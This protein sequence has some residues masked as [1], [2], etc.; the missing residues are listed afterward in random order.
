MKNI[1]KRLLSLAIALFMVIAMIPAGVLTAS[2]ATYEKA[3]SIAVGD[4][5]ILVCES[6]GMEMSS[7]GSAK[8]GEGKAYSGSPA[9]LVELTVEAGSASD[10]FAFKTPA[11]TY[12]YWSSSNTLQ[13]TS[14]V[15][16]NSSWNVTFTDGNA[17]IANVKDSTRV[18]LWNASSP[19]F[20]CYTSNQTAIQLY[21][22][23]ASSVECEH[24]YVSD[25]NA[26]AATCTET[27]LTASVSC[28]LCGD[29]QTKQEEIAALGHN[30]VDGICSRCGEEA[31]DVSVATSIAVG[32]TVY[33][34]YEDDSKTV[35][36]A[37]ISDTSTKYGL[38]AAYSDVPAGVMPL[39]VVAGNAEGTVAFQTAD[40][41]YLTWTSGNSLNVN[42]TLSDN[43][44]W[45]VSFDEDGY[46]VILNGADNTRKLQWNNNAGQERFAAY[47]STQKLVKLYKENAEEQ[48]NTHDLTYYAAVEA[49]CHQNGMA[50]YW[51]CAECD[52]VFADEAATIVTNR[53]NLTI[54]YTAEIAHVE[55]V[56]ANCHQNGNVEYWYC[57]ECEAVFTDAALTQLSNFK[58]VIIPA[59][60]GLTHVE[61]VEAG[62]H[63][64]GCQEY[65]YC[66][67]C[68]CVFADAAA[69]MLTN[70]K[71]LVIVAEHELAYVEA[72]EAGLHQP[73]VAE[74][75][76]C[77]DCDAFFAD[78]N[79]IQLTNYKNLINGEAEHPLTY[80]PA[81]E[82]GL[83]QNGVAE[84]WYCEI[85]D[86]IF[87][88]ANGIVLT[89]YKNL[90]NG[91]AE[92]P[93]TYVPAVEAGLHQN[94][95]AEYWYCETC[96]AIFADA[97]GIQLTNYKN[98]INGE[99]EHPL[100]YVAA[101]EAGLHTNGCAEYWY[102][103]TCDAVFADPNGIQLT[104][105]KNLV[106]L[107]EH[108]LAYVE[109]VEAG[110]HQNGVAEYWYC[111]D[112][113]AFFADADGI[114]LTN[115]K[116]LI[117][118]EAEHPLTYVA[119]VEAGV[120]TNGCAEYWYCETCDA[121]F[122]DPNG[123]QLTNRKN[124]V[125]V[126]EHELAYVEAVEAG[127]H[128]NGVAEYWY[129]D[130]C[131]AF[132][133]DAD[134]IYQ[135][136]Y[137]NLI[138]GEAEHPL[139]YVAAVEAGLHQNGVA[140]YWYCEICDAIFADP[141]GIQLTNYKNL[142]NGEAEHPLT[143]VAAVEA[144][145]HT[146]G[147][148][149]YWY[150]ETCDAVFAD[151]NGIQLTNRKNLV[152]LAEH[153]LAYVAAVEA[154]LH[155]NG[156]AEYWYC[157]DCDAFFADAD[158]IYQTNYKNL[159]NGEA[160][161]PLT[162][163]AAVE[164][165]LHQNGV[166]EYWYCEI[167][168]A[169]FADPNGIQLTNYKNLIN[170]EAEHPLTYVA[171]VEAT[172]HQPGMAEYWYC[173]VC[174]AFF[175]DPNGIQ[176]T[177]AKN[178]ITEPAAPLTYVAAVEAGLH[179][180]GCAEYWYCEECMAVFTDAQGT[181]LTNLKNLVIVAEHE[182]AYVEAVEA[183]LHQNGV[184]EYWYCDDCDAFFA[185][186]D[187]IVLT[188]YKNLI[189]GYAEHPLT[190]VAAVEAGLHQNGVAEYWYCEICDTI[191]A[192]ANGIQVTNYKNLINGYAEHPLTYVP[193][194]EAGLHQNGVAEYWYCEIC[195][196]IF[197][198]ANGIQLTNY[199]NLIN[200]EAEHPLTYVPAV[201][202]TCH[203]PGMAEYWYCAVCDAFFA[204]PNGIQLTNAK[205]L[206]TEPAAPL[207]YVPAVAPTTEQN[208][209]YEYWY[210]ETCDAV[211]ADAQG[212][213]LTNRLNLTIPMLTKVEIT[214][215]PE[216]VETI[217]NSEVTFTVVANGEGLTYK[218]Q[219]STNGGKSWYK[220]SFVGKD[221]ATLTVPATAA[222]DG[223][224]YRCVITDVNGNEVISEA[225]KLTVKA[226]IS[227]QP[228]DVTAAAGTIVT[229][230]ANVE[231]VEVASY[232]WQYSTNGGQCWFAS[233]TFEG[234][235][236]DTLYVP[237]TAARDGFLYRCVIT[238]ADGQT[239]I[240]EAAELNVQ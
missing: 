138:N 230:S 59:T 79:G 187:G 55:A 218:W 94:G 41:K 100:T 73:G 137:K 69:T 96:D 176:L 119:A 57:T 139:T 209:H 156:V 125:I 162:Y 143:Y 11:G 221:T 238:T 118:G 16:D 35:E 157:D 89:N 150:C 66:T 181:Q 212:T 61:A 43:T 210:C 202:A 132:F 172:C 29:V 199:K 26:K 225:G 62:L 98:L 179:T 231:G 83:H 240:T 18:I 22:L 102:C 82:A 205:N 48:V 1:G 155:Q 40:G 222:R 17:K 217:E 4:T 184:A 107:A 160:E 87:A 53:M 211:F 170:G 233:K 195:D 197:A 158:G 188:N 14:S 72:V 27:G 19:R 64:N 165:G 113:D 101:V 151:P 105:R 28:T 39:A 147:C 76:Y 7:I 141:N 208:G 175:A 226:A 166:A 63:T 214:A 126:A 193:A 71:N 106:V 145:V 207:T 97:N 215:Q 58:S 77:D 189:N 136:N 182:L 178:L 70:R 228:E 20:A 9:G 129:C 229:F 81:V 46:A 239:I 30:Y 163:V 99:A 24:N 152:V 213:I 51:Y 167:C 91:E 47:T 191:F 154:G 3:T 13:T 234:R 25:N 86:A 120:H 149:E 109:A 80:V 127:L 8:Y 153:E 133:A 50:E 227:G 68:D 31:L 49:N 206:I 140:E 92:H 168:D 224:L 38:Y 131:D 223:F 45:N 114:Q 74:Y 144:G 32:D 174:D 183:G 232:K 56:E 159:I 161:H 75:W 121:V 180:K 198:D 21:K 236:S 134:G 203:Q 2:A 204:D 116:N 196:A 52:C 65:W 110:L 164:A 54:P 93:L 220:S 15:S 103:E 115:Y 23:S 85:C 235:N 6:K 95:V 84:Y 78:A 117:N 33:L 67:E 186:A 142:I 173:A 135:T 34:V 108:E 148:A 185:D 177:N 112:C 37:G 216:A 5:V 90:I 169:I 194:V 190:Y 237:A 192:D 130:D 44:S 122:A 146:N 123:I 42:A 200:G 60:V 104:N 219:Y 12:L 171:A 111:D 128:Q 88:D 201:E 10:S 124:L 36:L